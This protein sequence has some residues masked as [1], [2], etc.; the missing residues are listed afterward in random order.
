MG[1]RKVLVRYVPPDF[2]PSIIPKFKHDKNRVVEVRMMLPFS[3]RCLTCGEY[4]GMGKKFNSI[5][6][7][8][9]GEDY[10]GIRKI[11]FRI[12]CSMCSAEIS[13]KTDPKNSGYECESG[14]SRN[15]EVWAANDAEREAQAE[16]EAQDELDAMKSLENRTI[17][18]KVEMDILDALDEIKSINQR[19]E[20]ANTA[21][22]L[23]KTQK[24]QREAIL[25]EDEEILRN[26]KFHKKQSENIPSVAELVQSQI[27]SAKSS[28][29]PAPA[30]VVLTRKKRPATNEE[31]IHH[32]KKQKE[33][34]A[35][36]NQTNTS[37]AAQ[38]MNPL[39]SLLG[40]Y[41]SDSD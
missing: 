5:K 41:G 36:G 28:Q 39:S 6:E 19:H 15:F 9:W 21:L 35:V 2:D 14:A 37:K 18:S 16:Q 26:T 4:M 38:P 29:R 40:S 20:H 17:D 13:F 7:I 3:M 24:Q 30:A 12:K 25:A 22:V 23:E 1:E 27:I 33:E 34:T 32:T 10:M 31:K 11:R 8:C